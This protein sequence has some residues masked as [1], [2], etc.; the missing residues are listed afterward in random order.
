[1]PRPSTIVAALLLVWSLV[2]AV[3][4]LLAVFPGARD[5]MGDRE[6]EFRV[7][8]PYLPRSGDVGYLD[9]YQGWTEDAVRTHYAAQYSLSPRVIVTRLDQEFLIVARDAARPEQDSR[10]T[11]FVPVRTFPSGH[12]LFRRFP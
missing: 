6:A 3:T 9:P 2:V 5:D 10:L 7:F 8:T 4:S 1:M 12:R 11:R